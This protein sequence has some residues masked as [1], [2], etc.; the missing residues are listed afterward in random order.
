MQS[1][2]FWSQVVIAAFALVLILLKW[3]EKKDNMQVV[4]AIAKAI[5]DFQPHIERTRQTHALVKELA[6][7]HRASDDTGRPFVYVP[8]EFIETQREISKTL[9]ILAEIQRSM[10][11]DYKELLHSLSDHQK[12]CR[13][14]YL[15]LKEAQ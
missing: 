13:S 2:T 9:T 1:V 14:Q 6:K 11:G 3:I 15:N 4:Q 5:K 12:E 10:S 8:K 7:F